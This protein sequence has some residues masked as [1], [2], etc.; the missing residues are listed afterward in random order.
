MKYLYFS[1]TWCGACKMIKPQLKKVEEAGIEVTNYDAEQD[2]AISSSYNIRNLPTL[3]LADNEGNE[4]KRF[5]GTKQKATDFINAYNE[6][7]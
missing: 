3:I 1:A 4:V 7:V 2:Y 6:A 5:V